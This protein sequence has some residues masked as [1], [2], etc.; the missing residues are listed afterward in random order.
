MAA[1]AAEI[2]D[3]AEGFKSYEIANGG[4]AGLCAKPNDTRERQDNVRKNHCR[5]GVWREKANSDPGGVAEKD[6]DPEF[7]RFKTRQFDFFDGHK[8]NDGNHA[9]DQQHK[10]AIEADDSANNAAYARPRV[11]GLFVCAHTC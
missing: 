3:Q 10:A 6:R 2:Y 8:S 9:R 1:D 4:K 11:P 5:A 7:E